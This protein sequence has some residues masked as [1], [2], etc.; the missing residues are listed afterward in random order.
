MSRRLLLPLLAVTAVLF[1]SPAAIASAPVRPVDHVELDRYTGT[2]LQLAAIPQW[3]SFACVRNTTATYTA[4][5]GGTIGVTNRCQT[6][7]GFPFVLDGRARVNDPVSNAQLQVTFLG[8][9][10]TWVYVG[11]TNYVIIGLADDYSWAVTTD[12]ARM[13]AFVLSRTPTLPWATQRR[14]KRILRSNGIDPCRL[15]VTPL[16]G[17]ATSSRPAC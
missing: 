14:I 5:P 3:F 2:W 15:R 9:G 4:Q 12:P 11:G 6:A 16:T 17:G 8:S 10:D 13:S 1:V 7:F